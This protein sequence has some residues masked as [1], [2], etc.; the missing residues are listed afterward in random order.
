MS[1]K[2]G[3]RRAMKVLLALAAAWLV[4]TLLAALLIG[5]EAKAAP[6]AKRQAAM[7]RLKDA[8]VR[9]GVARTRQQATEDQEALMPYVREV[10][11]AGGGAE[12][13]TEEEQN[14]SVTADVLTLEPGVLKT[15]HVRTREG[16]GGKKE[17]EGSGTPPPNSEPPFGYAAST[18]YFKR[19]MHS[20]TVTVHSAS[21]A[22]VK[23][24]AAGCY[25]SVAEQDQ[26]YVKGI[27]TVI[28]WIYVRVNGW[29]GNPGV[30][31]YWSGGPTFANWAWGPFCFAGLQTNW[32]WDIFPR[33]IH[34]AIWASQGVPYPFG[35]LGLHGGKTQIRIAAS[36]Y[37][38]TYNDYG[39]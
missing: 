13:I 25:G 10:V 18:A 31:I 20:G 2:T 35:C 17:A 8:S 3:A 6:P 39:F 5:N 22:S 29:C 14:P 28:A 27:G 7:S 34:T 32:S 9:T 16:R 19:G 15:K 4:F 24:H 12:L 30:N 21:A 36:G 1:I 38:D 23:A 11:R 26:W 33:W 37:A